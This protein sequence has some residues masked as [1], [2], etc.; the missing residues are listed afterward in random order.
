[1]IGG[2]IEFKQTI[3]G[4][5]VGP[6]EISFSRSIRKLAHWV[7]DDV[8][9]AH[10]R[11]P[12]VCDSAAR[13]SENFLASLLCCSKLSALIRGRGWEIGPTH[14]DVESCNNAPISGNRM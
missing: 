13:A 7:I 6:G 8:E 9:F 1:M 12:Q 11:R 4:L 3:S 10:F 5:M 14:A 2:R